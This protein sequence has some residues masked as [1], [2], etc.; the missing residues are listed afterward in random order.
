MKKQKI[1][2]SMVD[3]YYNAYPQ[4]VDYFKNREFDVALR[5]ESM[6][7]QEQTLM[8]LFT[9]CDIC[10]ASAKP[11][12]REMIESAPNLRLIAVFGAGYNQI[13][14]KAANEKGIF[15]TNARGGNAR[16][17][18]EHT[19][20]TFLGLARKIVWDDKKVRANEWCNPMGY[21]IYG[22]TLGIVGFGAI[23]SEIAEIAKGGFNMD[24]L[25]HDPYIDE[26]T[27]RQY[28]ATSVP[29]SDLMSMADFISINT[30][31][32]DMTKYLIDE[33]MLSLMKKS[34]YIV[35]MSRGGIIK[36]E[37]LFTA[38]SEKRI[39]GAGL[40]VHENEP[41]G[42]DNPSKFKAFDNVIL[43]SH[44]GAGTVEAVKKIGKII[45]DNVEDVIS[46][47]RP[48]HNIVNCLK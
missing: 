11:V 3:S 4:F 38:L 35:N 18:A 17:V 22:K 21:E 24:I 13:D 44:T 15:V 45:I 12:T 25:V 30:P 31:L 2:I 34:A 39:A 46:G 5:L 6:P 48:R 10:I 23:G 42:K 1:Y 33:K 14:I 9:D 47:K 8:E 40:D 16:A 43:T 36:E 20:A 28:G 19:F 7:I 29:L 26:K 37:A 41:F 27:I 32:N